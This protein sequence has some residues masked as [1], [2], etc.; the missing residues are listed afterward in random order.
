MF[1]DLDLHAEI[2]NTKHS[3]MACIAQTVPNSQSYPSVQEDFHPKKKRC[4]N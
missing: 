1:F 3:K 4:K 2:P